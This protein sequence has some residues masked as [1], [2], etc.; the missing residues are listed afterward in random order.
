MGGAI[1]VAVALLVDPF[2]GLI[3]YQI[4]QSLALLLITVIGTGAAA[5]PRSHRDCLRH[6][7][8]EAT[9]ATCV[10]LLAASAN[11]LDQIV[12]AALIGSVPLASLRQTYRDL[13]LRHRRRIVQRDPLQPLFAQG[14]T[15]DAAKS[16]TQA[17]RC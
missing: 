10:R 4:S 11:N 17:S 2:A 15:R 3:A 9:L 7:R 8:R 14:R 5:W 16:S 12:V 1:G 13:A 6:M